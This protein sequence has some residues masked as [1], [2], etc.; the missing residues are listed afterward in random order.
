MSV[1]WPA[2][3]ARPVTDLVARDSTDATITRDGPGKLR[4][5]F[6]PYQTRLISTE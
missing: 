6:A 4:L 1:Q 5:D 3:D 2:A